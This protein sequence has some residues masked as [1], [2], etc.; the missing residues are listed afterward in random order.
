MDFNLAREPHNTQRVWEI[1]PGLPLAFWREEIL[2]SISNKIGTFM[3]LENNWDSKDDKRW[4]L[5]QVELDTRDGPLEMIDLVL[6][7]RMWT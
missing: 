6:G 2:V 1:F 3:G 5:I 7:G 4:A